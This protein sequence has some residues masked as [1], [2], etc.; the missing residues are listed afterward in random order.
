MALQ[1]IYNLAFGAPELKSRFI[2]AGLQMA[3]TIINEDAG[4]ANHAAR[5]A[6]A[7]DMVL[8]GQN[9]PVGENLYRICLHNATIQSSGAA[10]TDSDINWV[11]NFVISDADMLAAIGYA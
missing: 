9:G 5:L 4:T 10:S 6:W 3:Y 11:V 7:K 1:D 8:D 2:G